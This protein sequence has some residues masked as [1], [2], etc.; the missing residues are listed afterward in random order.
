L[1]ECFQ[2]KEAVVVFSGSASAQEARGATSYAVQ[3]ETNSGL[4]KSEEQYTIASKLLIKALSIPQNKICKTW[5]TKL[6]QHV[7]ERIDVLHNIYRFNPKLKKQSSFRNWHNKISV[8][9]NEIVPS[10]K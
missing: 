2:D 4:M 1:E 9:D 8:I 7:L 3:V 5:L 10:L 6:R